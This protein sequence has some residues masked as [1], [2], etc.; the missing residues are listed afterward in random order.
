MKPPPLPNACAPMTF[1]E[2][3]RAI[4]PGQAVVLY[5]DDLVIGGGFIVAA[6]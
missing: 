5:R 1:F 3:Q 6:S 2:P 4:P